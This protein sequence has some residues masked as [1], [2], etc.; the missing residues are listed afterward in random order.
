MGV[1]PRGVVTVRGRQLDSGS[2]RAGRLQGLGCLLLAA[3]LWGCSAVPMNDVKTASDQTEADRRARVRLE[4]ASAYFARGQST[5]ALDEVKLALV[6]RPDL[7]EAFNLR[8]LIY[9]ALGEPRLAEESFKRALQLSPRDGEALHNFAWF[10][11]QER[12][13]PEADAMFGQALALPQYREVTRTLLAR[14]VCQGRAG[15]WAQAQA[16]LG[17]AYELDP[18]NLFSGF[19]L[20]EALYRQ[21]EFERAQFYLRRV[22]QTPEFAGPGALW[23]AVRLERRMGD[24]AAT[25]AAAQQL[26]DRFPQSPEALL[27]DKG[28]FDD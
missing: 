19:H 4:L 11:C 2:G 16:T 25:R 23:L 27:L 1:G 14:G 12:R 21:G 10:L 20:S 8:G 7:P 26:K 17:R 15:Q 6:A 5:T 9:G 24:A 22:L 3:L 13:H 28:R 18:A